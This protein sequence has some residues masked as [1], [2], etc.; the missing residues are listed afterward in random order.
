MLATWP[1]VPPFALVPRDRLSDTVILSVAL[2]ALQASEGQ[3]HEI[4]VV[5]LYLM[6]KSRSLILFDGSICCLLLVH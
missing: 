3:F 5:S 2:A 6:R 1:L 4:L